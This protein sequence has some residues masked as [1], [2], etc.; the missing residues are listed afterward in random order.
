MNKEE[1][2]DYLLEYLQINIRDVEEYTQIESYILDLFN[3]QPNTSTEEIKLIKL[4]LITLQ[5]Y[6]DNLDIVSQHQVAVSTY[7]S[8]L[9]NY[10]YQLDFDQYV[11][12]LDDYLV[13]LETYSIN[14][15]TALKDST[16]FTE[17]FTEVRPVFSTEEPINFV[18]NANIDIDG[19]PD[20]P[21]DE[22]LSIVN[23]AILF[24]DMYKN[25]KNINEKLQE[26][27]TNFNNHKGL[28]VWYIDVLSDGQN[29]DAGVSDIS[30]VITSFKENYEIIV[31]NISDKELK[32]K[33]YLAAMS[34]RSYDVFSLWL[35]HT[36]YNIENV[37][38]EEIFLEENRSP[39]FDVS[40]VVDYNFT[41]DALG[42]VATLFE[43]ESVSWIIT[44]FKYDYEDGLFEEVFEDYEEVQDVLASTKELVDEYDAKYKDIANSIEG[45]ISMLFKIGIS[46]MKYNL[47]VYETLENTPL[48]SAVFNDAARFCGSL[49]NVSGYDVEI[50]QKSEGESGMFKE[51]MNMRYLVSEIYFKA[52]LM[53]DDDNERLIYNTKEMHDYLAKVNKSVKDNVITAEVITSIGNQFAFNIIDESNNLTLLEQMYEEGYITIEAMRVLAEDEYELFSEDFRARVRSLIR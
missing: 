2:K 6:Q 20:D 25:K 37:E 22:D 24:V 46:V 53:V 43:G 5:A 39:E 10:V 14:K 11:K 16:I 33:L 44:Q 26:L 28:L 9:K 18:Y 35:E 8:A 32:D 7:E 4:L 21:L 40:L 13:L 12:D 34:I 27:G 41:D 50:C 49:D 36:T 31:D 15:L 42:I 1:T 48:I 3:T 23:E 38:L 17:T 29:F 47:D 52:Y 19:E 51:I 45:N 30:T